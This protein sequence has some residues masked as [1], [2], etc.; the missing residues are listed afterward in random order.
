[1]PKYYVDQ[2]AWCR[3]FAEY[4]APTYLALRP[5]FMGYLPGHKATLYLPRL[6]GGRGIWLRKVRPKGA[7]YGGKAGW[8]GLRRQGG[9]APF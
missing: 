6:T 9:G 1:M 8:V 4:E 5:V 7:P 2:R 3:V